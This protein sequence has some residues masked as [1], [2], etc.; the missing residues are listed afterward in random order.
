MVAANSPSTRR[1]VFN[2]MVLILDWALPPSEGSLFH[3]F[4]TLSNQRNAHAPL[5][6]LR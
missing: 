6:A 2:T 3:A 1:R 4:A 5:G